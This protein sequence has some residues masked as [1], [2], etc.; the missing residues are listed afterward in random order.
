MLS[1]VL[2]IKKAAKRILQIAAVRWVLSA[3]ARSAREREKGSSV[4]LI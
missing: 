4:I 1:E 2:D 3:G